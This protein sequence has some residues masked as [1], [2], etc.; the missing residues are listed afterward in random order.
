MT[1]GLPS[2]I[3]AV[4]E[5]APQS[6]SLTLGRRITIQRQAA[7]LTQRQLADAIGVTQ[8]AVAKWEADDSVPALRH[9][10]ALCATLN[11]S[12]GILFPAEAAW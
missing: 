12:L 7:C 9:R 6:A 8:S 11:V 10:Q 3:V 2:P 4:M 1:T 5:P